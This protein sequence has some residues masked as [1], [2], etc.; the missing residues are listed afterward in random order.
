MRSDMHAV[1][2]QSSGGDAVAFVLVSW[3]KPLTLLA[4]FVAWAYVVATIYDKD[5]KKW[6]LGRTK[7]NTI[8]LAAGA[9]A[10]A[11]ALAAPSFLLAL[12]VFALVLLADLS[13]YWIAHNRSERVPEKARWRFTLAG[14]KAM[15]RKDDEKAV[16]KGLRY[17]FR[18]PEG[19]LPAP[20][21]ETPEYDV[22]LAVETIIADAVE[23]RASRF[24]LAPAQDKRYSV[25]FIIDGVRKTGEPLPAAQAVAVIDFFKTAAGL[26]VT[27][28]RRRQVG[29]FQ[30]EREN[31][32]R[33][34]RVTTL[35]DAR[36]QRLQGVFDPA[37]QVDLSVEDLGLLP[38]QRE[39]LQ[40]IIEEQKG[41]VLLAAPPLGGRTTLLYAVLRAHDAYLTNIQTV[42]MQPEIYI[43]GVRQNQFD[44]MEEGAE[45]ATTV[46]SILRR[47][48]DIVAVAELPDAETAKTI[49]TVNDHEHARVFLALRG[50]SAMS[51]IAAYVKAVGDAKAAG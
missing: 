48:P 9:L 46:R 36:G 24:D 28:R 37:K 35:G 43:D 22:R 51:A 10:W 39:A 32:K 12:P 42:E 50:D 26:D 15:R 2:A 44:P 8:H 21:K 25:S 3:W 31:A 6:L 20:E 45:Y 1:L 34:V 11:G 49:A 4:L 47:D 18:G 23:S 14:L 19:L 29:E 33:I 7:W 5:A 27:D 16:A 17:A 41:V 40:Q 38:K 13:A 30:V